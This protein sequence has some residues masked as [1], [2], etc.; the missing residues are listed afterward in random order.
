MH[1]R[2]ATHADRDAIRSV[3]LSAFTEDE[4]EVVAGL[5][6]RLLAEKSSPPTVGLVADV[7][8]VVV[9]HVAFSPVTVNGDARFRGYIL[10]PLAVT[11]K[12]QKRGLG[13]G[14]VTAGMQ[15][16]TT[17]GIDIIFVYGDPAYYG[18]FG[19]T[20]DAATPYRPPHA[21]QYPHGWQAMVLTDA[22]PARAPVDLKCVAA[23]DDP[24]LW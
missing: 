13:S 12:Q 24:G 19:F 7:D 10:A 2:P 8:G 17:S 15:R 23:L 11:P 22:R 6:V 20:S 5:A 9:G 21:L 14:L 3:Y 18:R 16:L 1:I 4:A